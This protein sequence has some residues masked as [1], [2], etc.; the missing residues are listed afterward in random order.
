MTDLIDTLRAIK[1]LKNWIPLLEKHFVIRITAAHAFIFH[2]KNL[3]SKFSVR[4]APD[5]VVFSRILKAL[6]TALAEHS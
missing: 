2:K 3:I 6:E 5:S 1:H 4:K